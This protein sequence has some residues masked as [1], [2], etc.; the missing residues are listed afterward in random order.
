MAEPA[1]AERVVRDYWQK[2]WIEA[3]L[4]AL[5]DVV[6]EPIVRHTVDGTHELTL[7]AFRKRITEALRTMC[8]SGVTIDSITVDG[9]TVWARITLEGMTLATMTP[10][11]LTWMAQ[12][13]L[14]GD[15]IAEMWA[16][17][18]SGLDWNV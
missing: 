14:E 1:G 11:T 2:V 15:K 7:D 12:Y 3:D 16:L 18:R 6:T 13:R 8:G 9:D 4:D 17:H 5:A 10:L